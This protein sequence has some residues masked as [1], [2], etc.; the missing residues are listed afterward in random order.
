M[1]DEKFQELG[2]PVDHD[3]DSSR[4]SDLLD[5]VRPPTDS[6]IN[7]PF[8]TFVSRKYPSVGDHPMYLYHT[9]ISTHVC[10]SCLRGIRQ[11]T[12]CPAHNCPLDY[13]PTVI[14]LTNILIDDTL[15][16]CD[17]NSL[18]RDKLIL[19]SLDPVEIDRPPQSQSVKSGGTAAFYCYASGQ[20]TPSF[21]WKKNGKKLRYTDSRYDVSANP[22]QINL[23]LILN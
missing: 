4:G 3:Q 18:P 13:W 22:N 1:T 2:F 15:W 10:K 7:N 20:P 19:L 12:F 5:M 11:S 6:V 14:Y 8:I 16:I 21:T 9:I 23:M 17:D